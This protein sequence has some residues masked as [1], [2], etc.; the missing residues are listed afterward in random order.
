MASTVGRIKGTFVLLVVVA[1]GVTYA[2]VFHWNPLPGWLTWLENSTK[3]SLATPAPAWTQRSGDEPDSA[4][5]LPGGVVVSAEGVVEMRD[6]ATGGLDWSHTDSWAGVAGS[7]TNAVVIAGRPVGT[8]YDVYGLASGVRLW[9]SDQKAGI[10]PYSDK[11]VILTC[12]SPSS[13][14]LRAVDPETGHTEWSTAVHGS[15]SGLT[16]LRPGL[17]EPAA[18]AS[19]YAGSLRAVPRPA[20]PLIGLPMGA[21]VHV[22][23]TG[24]GRELH[25]FATTADT[26]VVVAGR[27]VVA[28]SATARGNQCYYQVRASDPV[29]GSTR[30]QHSGID[31]RTASGMGCE[32]RHDPYGSGGALLG[33]DTSGHDVLL[34]AQTGHE[35]YRAGKG[36]RV[37]AMDGSL[38]MIRSAD[39]K[40]VRAVSLSSGHQ[41]WTQPA[42][43]AATIGVAPGYVMVADPSGNGRLAVFGRSSGVTLA[44]VT[45][46]ATVL[47]IGPSSVLVNIGRSIGPIP[48][49]AAGP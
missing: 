21:T 47:G 48:V 24:D 30:W 18:V 13:C 44:S 20:P 23:R 34:S 36:E 26:R 41:L 31:L 15:G 35:L 6:P 19:A 7:T 43:P 5:V 4:T 33:I 17:A 9:G 3:R 28:A 29:T 22:F 40:T 46:T 10:W 27:E 12:S 49:S 39:R 38:A 16:G 14:V 42:A 25:S 1:L 2:I 11:I 37:V 32:S 45:S 8:G